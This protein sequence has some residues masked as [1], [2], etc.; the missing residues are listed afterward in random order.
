M[1]MPKILGT[2]LEV[3]YQKASDCDEHEHF[4]GDTLIPLLIMFYND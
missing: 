1:R 4:I 2:R 3:L